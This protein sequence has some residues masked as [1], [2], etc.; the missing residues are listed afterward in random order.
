MEFNYKQFKY[1]TFQFLNI[2][3][4]FRSNTR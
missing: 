4:M 1:K 3:E 2:V